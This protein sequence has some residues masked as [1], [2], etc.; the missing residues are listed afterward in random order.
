M[1]GAGSNEI[2]VTVATFDRPEIVTPA[3]HT[4]TEDRLHGLSW[5]TIYHNTR[6]PEGNDFVPI[7]IR[8]GDRSAKR[9]ETWGCV[10][11]V[12]SIG[13]TIWIVDAHRDDGKHFVVRTDEQLHA[14]VITFFAS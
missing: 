8:A 13:R 3:D 11:V 5:P 4:W 14:F 9:S 10:S 6:E 2:D 7:R 1:T 12:D